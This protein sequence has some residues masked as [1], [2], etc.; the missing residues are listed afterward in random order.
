VLCNLARRY[1]LNEIYVSVV[2]FLLSLQHLRSSC[3][4]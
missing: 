3:L 4:R 2:L 1:T